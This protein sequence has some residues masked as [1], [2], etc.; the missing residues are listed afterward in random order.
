MSKQKF[1]PAEFD[2]SGSVD[3]A[4]MDEAIMDEETSGATATAAAER[5]KIFEVHHNGE[6]QSFEAANDRDA[7]AMYC[8]RNKVYPSPKAGKVFCGGVQVYPAA[9]A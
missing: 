5:P 6:K 9:K 8:D 7:W 1:Q 4:I 2:S 3:E